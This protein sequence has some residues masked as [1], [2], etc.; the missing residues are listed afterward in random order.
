M[1]GGCAHA[2]P[3]S[4]DHHWGYAR[5]CDEACWAGR[6]GPR[7]EQL[8][9]GPDRDYWSCNVGNNSQQGCFSESRGTRLNMFL[10]RFITCMAQVFFPHLS[11]L[12]VCRVVFQPITSWTSR[13][14]ADSL[15]LITTTPTSWWWMMGP[16]GTTEW[17]LNCVAV[18]RNTSPKGILEAQVKISWCKVADK[19]LNL[20]KI[21]RSTVL[22]PESGVTIPVVCVV[23]DGG[24]GTLNVSESVVCLS[25][26]QSLSDSLVCLFSDHL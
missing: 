3:R 15:A 2:V 19:I 13:A 1:T 14:R 11:L 16:K 9:A 7:T 22:L 4:V 6:E 17:R 8:H 20:F 21:D 26:S 18:W 24:P 12:H 25:L 10:T 5:W 23:L